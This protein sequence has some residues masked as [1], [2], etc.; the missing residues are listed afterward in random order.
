MK[1]KVLENVPD[2][3]KLKSV[4]KAIGQRIRERRLELGLTQQELAA[5]FDLSYQQIQKYE[6]GMNRISAGRLSMIAEFLLTDINYFFEAPKYGKG[7][8]SKRRPRMV[9]LAHENISPEVQI[10]LSNLVT[11]LRNE[12]K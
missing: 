10:A 5:R 9:S 8:L 2:P 6:T 3:G 12:G 4:E 11:A 7:E 1:K